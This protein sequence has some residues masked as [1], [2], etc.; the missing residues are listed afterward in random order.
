M[1]QGEDNT[2]ELREEITTLSYLLNLRKQELRRLT[3]FHQILKEKTPYPTYIN[4]RT[5]TEYSP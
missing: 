3:P 4:P 1:K 2:E 5:L